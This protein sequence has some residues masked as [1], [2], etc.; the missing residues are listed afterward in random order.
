MLILTRRLGQSLTIHPKSTLDLK[1]PV[2]EL[3]RKG[4]IRSR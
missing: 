3:F 2:A 1:T 4:P